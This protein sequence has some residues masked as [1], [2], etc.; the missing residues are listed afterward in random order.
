MGCCQSD[1]ISTSETKEVKRTLKKD[2]TTLIQLES[3]LQDLLRKR[4]I[5]KKEDQ[6]AL[7]NFEKVKQDYENKKYILEQEQKET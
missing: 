6:I 2:K 7:Y 5:E 3:E 1:D 4:I